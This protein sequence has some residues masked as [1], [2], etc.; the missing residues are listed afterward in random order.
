MERQRERLSG[1][2]NPRAPG[3]VVV[4]D[5]DDRQAILRQ[6]VD[7][8]ERIPDT[9]VARG[10]HD[11]VAAVSRLSPCSLLYGRRHADG[12]TDVGPDGT[13]LIRPVHDLSRPVTA[14]LAPDVAGKAESSGHDRRLVSRKRS[15]IQKI[16]KFVG[17]D[18]RVDC[19]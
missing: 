15:A 1:G 9:A 7:L 14:K 12:V 10:A 16:G 18:S 3:I 19:F 13:I 2:L 11:G 4:D 6:G 5:H 17:N 8:H